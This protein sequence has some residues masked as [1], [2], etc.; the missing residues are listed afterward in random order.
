RKQRKEAEVSNDESKDE[1]HFPTPSS[2]PLPSGED[3]FILNELMVFCTSLQEQVLDLQEAKADQAK[4]IVALK[5]KV[6][7]LNKWRKSRSGGLR[8]L[9]KFGLEIELDDETQG[10]T[11]DDEMFGVDDLAEE[12]IVMDTTTG[13][14]EEH[15]IE[16]VSTA[17]P[18]T[19]DGEVVT[20]TTVK[21]SDAPTTDVTEDK[22]TMAQALAV[23]N[24]IKPKVVVQEQEMSTTILAAATTITTDVPTLRAKGKAKMI[25]PEVPIKKKDQ[26][27]IDEEFKKEKPVDDMDNLLFI[28]LKTV[29][30]HHV[31]DNT[32]KYQ[33]GLAKHSTL[34]VNSELICVKCNGCMLSDNHD[35][36]VL[37]V[38][39]ARVKS[40]SVK[41][42]LNRN[43]WKPTG[44]VFTNIRYTWR[45]TD[46]TFTIVGNACPLTKITTTTEVPSRKPIAIDTD[47][48][49]PVVTLVYLWKPK[50][51]KYNDPVSKSKVDISHETSV[52]CSPQQNGVV[53]RRNRTLIEAAHTMLIYAKGPLFLWADAVATACYTQNH[54]IVCHC[55]GKT[56]YEHLQ[57]DLPNLSFFHVFVALC[58]LTNDSENLGK[59]QSKADIGIFICYA[60][61]NKAF[62]IYNR[63]T[64]SGLALYEI[65]P[66]IIRSRLVPNPTPSTPFVPPLRTDW[67][68]LLQSLFDELLTPLPSVDHPAPEV[69]APIAKVV[70]LEPDASIGLPS[71]TT[72]NQDAPSPSKS[73]TT[74]ETQSLIIPNDVE[75]DNPDLD[76]AH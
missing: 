46:R 45:P 1:D 74:P 53:K 60:P 18:V 12:E 51:S 4:E 50:K 25:E 42:N 37:N 10:R 2:D 72:V 67:N 71:T 69:I 52:A 36:C 31:E 14:H 64:S 66:A 9:K 43:V 28:T 33:Q 65:T 47:I 55:H 11:N 54:S 13:E 26:M 57:D 49:K 39:T 21:D 22:I 75:K 32:W 5:K 48:P 59:L 41:K 15:I 30:E 34:N 7:K 35:L 6:T 23:L 56:P 3:R 27:R 8:R 29:F 68:M 76:I 73:Q 44:K 20:T 17:E 58:Y 61:T 19:T 24:S 40:K 16:D 38:V 70:A 63:R 62:R